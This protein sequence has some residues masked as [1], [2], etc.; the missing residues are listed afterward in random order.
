[1]SKVAFLGIGSMGHG[2][3]TSALRR[4]IPTI[5]WNLRPEATR[6]LAELGADVAETAADAARRAE[7]VVTMVTDAD[8]V[9]SIARDQGMLAALAPNAIWVQMSTIGVAGI[10]R[11]A[12]LVDAKRPDVVLLD[13]PVS[14]SKVP[15]EQGQL[16]IFASGP[17]EARSRV[18]PLFEALGQR[19]IWAGA[20]GAG[21]RLKVVNNTWLAFGAEAVAASVALALRLGLETDRLVDALDGSSLVSPWQAAKLQRIAKDDYSAQFALSLA[22]KDV[23]LALEATDDGRFAAFASLADEWQQAVD[24]GLGDEDV[25]VVTRVLE[26]QGRTTTT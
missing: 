18:A 25:T 12:A 19:T 21:S 17:D 5:V 13:A 1:M 4:D 3:A 9:I 8:A 14:G 20:V 2:M 7:I 23:H 22:L 10:E 11:V 24:D 6:D 26:R 15:A 16:T